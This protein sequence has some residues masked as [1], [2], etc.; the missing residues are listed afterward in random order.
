ME[1]DAET[2]E[3]EATRFLA[4]LQEEDENFTPESSQYSNDWSATPAQV[5]EILPTIH[6][7]NWHYHL[8][9][10]STSSSAHQ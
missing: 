7:N 10:I 4:M 9:H 1:I 5:Q 8:G 3:Y 6:F 2:S